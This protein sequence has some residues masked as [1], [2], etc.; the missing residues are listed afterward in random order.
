MIQWTDIETAL[1]GILASLAEIPTEAVTWG[2]TSARWRP[3]VHVQLH[4]LGGIRKIGIDERRTTYDATEDELIERVY[5]N[6]VLPISIRCETQ[7]QN[8]GD[9]AFALAELIRTRLSRSYIH[10]QIFTDMGLSVGEMQPINLADYVDD[11][12]RLRSLAVLDVAF[13]VAVSDTGPISDDLGYIDIV[14][15]DA[16]ITDPAGNPVSTGPDTDPD[17]IWDL[18]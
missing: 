2:A 17:Y 8:L 3:L 1:P 7:D 18:T 9:S 6:R 10:S 5:G 14:H 15:A 16:T 4:V 11:H 12:E 13:L